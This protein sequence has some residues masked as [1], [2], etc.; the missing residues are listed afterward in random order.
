MTV[1]AIR[2]TL[3]AAGFAGDLL[4]GG[5]LA[6]H[7]QEPRQD[8]S[9]SPVSSTTSSSTA[10]PSRPSS[11]AALPDA[12]QP[13]VPEQS[14]NRESWISKISA[15]GRI[16]ALLA[17]QMTEERVTAKDKLTIYVHQAFNPVA[18]L[19]P[20]FGTGVGMANP[21]NHYPHEWRAGP[22]AVGRLYGEFLVRRESQ[23]AAQFL[24]RAAFREDPRYLPSSSHNGL[25]RL[26]YALLFTLVD[27]S[28]GGR[29]MPALSNFTGAAANGFVGNAFLP[30]GYDDLRHAGRR[31]AIT[32]SRF[33]LSNLADEF[34]PEWGPLIGK[35]HI[36]IIHPPCPDG[37]RK[38]GSSLQILGL[39]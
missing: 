23:Q 20:L 22:G 13:Q 2:L 37:T 3:L 9:S 36:P 1:R 5:S 27:Q 4:L 31:S 24:T 8:G 14:K 34:C 18:L 21:P 38:G 6:L 39:H 33:A 7:A 29:R 16:P 35:L 32:F 26:S 11:A 30:A 12:P 19:P 28:D 17:P 15:S 10:S 25:M